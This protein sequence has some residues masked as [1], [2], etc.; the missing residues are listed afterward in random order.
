MPANVRAVFSCYK[1]VAALVGGDEHRTLRILRFI[2]ATRLAAESAAL[3]SH[4]FPAHHFLC[5]A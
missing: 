2:T 5:L 1:P 4:V 3:H